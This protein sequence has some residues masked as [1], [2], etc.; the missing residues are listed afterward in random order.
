MC[1]P[2]ANGYTY[3]TVINSICRFQIIAVSY[4]I[5]ELEA[6][7]ICNDKGLNK[8]IVYKRILGAH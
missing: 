2:E 8:C 1:G 4:K 5:K 7:Q 3:L 6:P